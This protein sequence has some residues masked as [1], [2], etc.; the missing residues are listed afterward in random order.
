MTAQSRSAS[1]ALERFSTSLT[2][3]DDPA[4]FI[5]VADPAILRDLARR[6]DARPQS[7]VPL[8]GLT[9]AVKDN[10]DVAGMPTTAGC[11]AFAYEPESSAT[12]V[13]R[14]VDAGALPVGKTNLDQFATGLVGTRSPYGTPRNPLEPGHVPGGSSSGSAVAVA[15]GLVDFALGTD[16][17]GSG[18]VPAA[19]CGIIGLKPTFG[20]LSTHGSVPAV[21]SADCISIFGTDFGR[22]GDILAAADGFDSADAFSRRGTRPAVVRPIDQRVGVVG[23]AD[24]AAAGA[25]RAVIDSYLDAC[26]RLEQRI[27][28][29]VVVDPG[30]FFEAGD[31][32]YG[33]P[34]VAERTAAVGEFVETHLDDVDPVVRAIIMSGRRF[35]AV[36]AHRAGYRLRELRRMVD[37]CFSTID[38]L[39][40]PTVPRG[41]LV[42]EVHD[43]PV[44]VNTELGRFTTFANL[45]DLAAISLPS[46]GSADTRIPPSVTLYAPAWGDESLIRLGASLS[47]AA[48]REE[49][50]V[51]AGRDVVRLVVAGAHLRG[52]PLE[53]QLVDLGACFDETT[54]TAASYRLYALDTS[55]PPKPG[56][57][58][59]PAG[60]SI[61]VD[62]WKLSHDALGR[63]LQLVPPPL[64]LGTVELADGTHATGFLCEPRALESATDITQYGGWRAFRASTPS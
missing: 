18:R 52:Q 56:L 37:Q 63:F 23:E 64:A 60:R 32:L 62:V 3:L 42:R 55:A 29:V 45:L 19:F 27:A 24:L 14:L 25:E 40:M 26:A 49:P 22:L 1:E 20:R 33:G 43:D 17:A 11:P 46:A 15:R 54:S 35:D 9:F 16:T 28:E 2:D 51:P 5:S 39:M 8:R 59:D 50:S 41:A 13:A 21:R 12:T 38:T 30:P 61:E 6:I 34:W 48:E 10:I 57:V 58:F 47:R 44:G 36:D 31:M 7:D 53:H 4:I